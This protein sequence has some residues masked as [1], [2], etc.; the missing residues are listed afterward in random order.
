MA[1][2]VFIWGFI[3]SFIVGITIPMVKRARNNYILSLIFLVTA[4]NILFQYLLRYQELKFT[5][6]NYLIVPDILDLFLPTLILIYINEIMGKP[7]T[8]KRYQYFAIPLLW[9]LVLIGYVLLKDDFNFRSYIGN[10]F[11]KLDLTVIFCWKLFLSIKCYLLFNFKDISLKNKQQS[12]L[13]WPRVLSIFLF[14]LTY[15]ALTNLVYWLIIGTRTPDAFSEGLQK[16]VEANYLVLTCS[17]IF[18]TIF[19]SFKFPKILSGLPVIKTMEPN[20]FPEAKTY[21]RELN[22]LIE[23]KKIHLDTELNEKKLAEALGIHSYILSR[24]L[25]DHLG[26]SFNEFI[27][28]KRID[29]AKRILSDP[30]NKNVTIFAVAIDSGFRTESVFYVNFK[31]STG[32]TPTQYKKKIIKENAS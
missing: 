15:I 4:L 1:E 27:N 3:Q 14:V 11:H 13:L 21:G 30:A 23:K 7:L 5:H 20:S 6:P 28:E 10:T 24:L 31:K 19:F 2:A 12:I 26:K 17:I 22:E 29:E 25:N 8:K 16:L 18:V 9:S 32:I